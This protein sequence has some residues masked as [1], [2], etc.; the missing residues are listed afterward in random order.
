[1]RRRRSSNGCM[2]AIVVSVIIATIGAVATGGA[3]LQAESARF[4]GEAAEATAEVVYVREYRSNR[5]NPF[6]TDRFYYRPTVVFV[7]NDLPESARLDTVNDEAMYRPG[8]TVRIRFNSNDPSQAIDVARLG[9]PVQRGWAG[10]ATM[11]AGFASL[12]LSLIV[13]SR[14]KRP[15]SPQR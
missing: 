3:L 4:G 2:A 12:A 6:V 9:E 15:N 13:R 7:Y 1:M 5:R 14:R 8:D 11:I 10:V